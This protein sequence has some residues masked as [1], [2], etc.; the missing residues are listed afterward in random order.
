MRCTYHLE[1]LPPMNM[2][3]VAAP[4]AHLV[5]T[6]PVGL[7]TP[8]CNNGS[9][10]ELS[11]LWW[12]TI[13]VANTFDDPLIFVMIG[14][15]IVTHSTMTLIPAPSV[16]TSTFDSNLAIEKLFDLKTLLTTKIIGI[17]GD[18]RWV[19]LTVLATVKTFEAPSVATST[20]KLKLFPAMDVT[21]VAFPSE[22]LVIALVP[23]ARLCT[24]SVLAPTL[25]CNDHS[26]LERDRRAVWSSIAVSNTANNK[27]GC[28]C[29]IAALVTANKVAMV[30]TVP[31][32]PATP[33]PHL[34]STSLTVGETF[35]SPNTTRSTPDL[36]AMWMV[37]A[38]PVESKT[39]EGNAPTT[40]IH[41]LVLL[42]LVDVTTVALQ[43]V[44]SSTP[45]GV[46]ATSDSNYR[47]GHNFDWCSSSAVL[48]ALHFE[49]PV[50]EQIE[51][52]VAS[53]T[54]AFISAEPTLPATRDRNLVATGLHKSELLPLVEVT[55]VANNA[56]MVVL[57]CTEP[58]IVQASQAKKSTTSI[59]D[60]ELVS[61]VGLVVSSPSAGIAIPL[62]SCPAVAVTACTLE[63]YNR[64]SH[65]LGWFWTH[66]LDT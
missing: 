34:T 4:P 62:I 39:L 66:I 9:R 8:E 54:V 59:N 40:S 41:D 19:I 50:L 49:F 15:T 26:I 52:L 21:T 42:P 31:A 57:I 48:Q 38:V 18:P 12:C 60:L 58:L 46:L 61:I 64:S 37:S 14:V 11:W 2:T 24:P 53:Y 51:L 29:T 3:T 25:K 43:T 30:S 22:S 20:H 36:V 32:C 6:P 27:L 28:V 65:H 47:I 7:D 16:T 1:L 33:Q 23:A 17:A 5:C 35:V 44:F 10:H 56:G 55:T 45:A 63:G 13:A